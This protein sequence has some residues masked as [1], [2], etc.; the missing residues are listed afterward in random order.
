MELIETRS[1]PAEPTL[2]LPEVRVGGRVLEPAMIAAEMQYHPAASSHEAQLEAARALVVRELMARRAEMLGFRITEEN[3]QH[4]V[5]QLLECE[6]DVPEPDDAACRRYFEANRDRFSQPPRYRVR[7]ILL[8]AAPDDQ[9]A[10]DQARALGN[11]LLA[12]LSHNPERFDELA[13]RYSACPSKES[14]GALGELRPGQTVPELD[15]ILK[16]L[17][18]GLCK[19][20]LA[21]R[22]GWHLVSLDERLDGQPADFETVRERVRRVL[23]EQSTR[24]AL[25]HYLLALAEEIGVE[26]ICL[27]DDAAGALMQ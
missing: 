26:G 24:R 25:R 9:M 3:E 16:R 18:E 12:E 14:G 17:P 1:L 27:D 2:S 23:H 8:P 4:C 5:S 10:R 6:I 20:P 11:E 19:R 15:N 13:Q 7:H 21:S 22:Y